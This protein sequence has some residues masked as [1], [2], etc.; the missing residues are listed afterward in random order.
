MPEGDP[1]NHRNFVPTIAKSLG[2]RQGIDM[3]EVQPHCAVWRDSCL[4]A[5]AVKGGLT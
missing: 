3:L 1:D 4:A 2:K 5:I